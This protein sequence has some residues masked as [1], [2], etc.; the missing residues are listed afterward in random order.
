M[1][2]CFSV[3]RRRANKRYFKESKGRFLGRKNLLRTVLEQVVRARCV[4]YRGRKL[5][6]RDFRSLWIIRIKAAA[7]ARGVSYSLFI[8]GMDLAGLKL[9]R[10]TLSQ[11]AIN[12]PEVFDEITAIVKEALANKKAATPA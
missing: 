7:T 3:A 9:N 8:H 4:A 10:K 2:I 1:R 6:K 12:S 11:L 5:R